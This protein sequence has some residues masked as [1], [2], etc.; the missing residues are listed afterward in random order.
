M[1][2]ITNKNI[3]RYTVCPHAFASLTKPAA[4]KNFRIISAY[5]D[6]GRQLVPDKGLA[7]F[8]RPLQMRS[9]F[10]GNNPT[11]WFIACDEQGEIGVEERLCGAM[12]QPCVAALTRSFDREPT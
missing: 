4:P 2:L 6:S 12:V 11:L 1:T 7:G 10:S 9:N 5:D 8:R 3:Q